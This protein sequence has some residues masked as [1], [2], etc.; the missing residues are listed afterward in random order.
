MSNNSQK[1]YFDKRIM[2]QVNLLQKNNN[3]LENYM[4]SAWLKK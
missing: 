4:N 2:F 1:E 3:I